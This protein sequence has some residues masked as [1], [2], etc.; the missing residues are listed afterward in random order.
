MQYILIIIALSLP[1]ISP[2]LPTS[3]SQI[4]ILYIFFFLCNPLSP[5]Q[6][7]QMSLNVWLYT[8]AGAPTRGPH[9]SKENRFSLSRS[10]Q[11]PIAPQIGWDLM[12]PSPW[13]VGYRLSLSCFSLVQA[14]SVAASFWAQR[15][16]AGNTILARHSPPL[17]PTLFV[18]CL[19][20]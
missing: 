14:N 17:A 16:C 12:R 7:A 11:L 5:V 19:L 9:T 6:A 13:T 10:H 18:S 15:S 4:C 2:R 1:P 8:G 20:R 3:P